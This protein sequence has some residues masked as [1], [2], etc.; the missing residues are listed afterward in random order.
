MQRVITKEGRKD[1]KITALLMLAGAVFVV[2][3]VLANVEKI[4]A[5]LDENRLL[6]RSELYT[7]LYFEDHTKIPKFL[8]P[9]TPAT[10]SFTIRNFEF[11]DREYRYRVMAK[12]G[13]ESA[14]IASGTARLGHA[15]RVT[16]PFTY[17]VATTEP[18][19]RIEATLEKPVQSVHFWI[20][21]KYRR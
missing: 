11:T 18:A 17:S 13:T 12:T 20:N 7:E 21:N 4:R 1:A 3:G 5:I 15:Q 14:V 19:T 9:N 16:I 6:P 8:E 10:A 2:F